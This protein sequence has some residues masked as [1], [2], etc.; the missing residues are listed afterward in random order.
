MEPFVLHNKP[1]E[2]AL[3]LLESWC[4]QIPGLTAGFSSKIGGISAGA[5]DSLNC[6]FHVQDQPEDV[7]QNREMIANSL[8]LP[9]E[10]W[11]C[12]EQVHSNHVVVVT[13]EHRG[14]GRLTRES[15]IQD[16]DALITNI[17][18]VWL[19]S[20]YADCVPLFFV[21]PVQRV[22]GL[23]HA[24]WKGTVTEIAAKTIEAMQNTYQSKPEEIRTSIGPSIGS[25]C[26]EVDEHVMQ[27]VLPLVDKFDVTE[28]DTPIYMAKPN[29]KYMLD[30]KQFN[31]HIMI[32]AGILPTNIECSTWC[33]SCHEENFF[34][35]RRDQGKTG[36]MISWIALAKGE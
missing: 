33:T 21:D 11:T 1:A 26:Y 23:A 24:G 19:T 31:R 27:H 10:A 29:G 18:D 32:K 28:Q 3:L 35:H 6:A 14:K 5:Y 20:F 4:N 36:R 25:C 12:A 15:A 8:K 16:T 22:V 34:S 9:F 30:L 17:P 13:E 2:P 7:I